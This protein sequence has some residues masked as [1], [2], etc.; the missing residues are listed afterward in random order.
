MKILIV[1]SATSRNF[2]LQIHQAFI[3][4][5]VESIKVIDKSIQFDYF[6]IK[7]KGLSGYLKAL[8][9]LRN[10]KKYDLIHAHGGLPA[11]LSVL[12]F[13][14]PVIS[15]FHGS[16]I[17]S[18]KTKLI[19]AFASLLSRKSIYV[20]QQLKEKALYK[21]NSVVI[22]CGVNLELFQPLKMEACR[23]TLNL[24]EKKKYILFS[25]SFS[26]PVKNFPLLEA[27]LKLWV[28]APPEVIELKGIGRELVPLYMNAVDVCVLTSFS[29]GSPQFI[30]EALACNR[31]VIAT[32]VGDIKELI[33]N[34]HNCRITNFTPDDLSNSIVQL[35]N[36]NISNGR[37]NMKSY[38]LGFIAAKVLKVYNRK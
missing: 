31:P 10:S 34:S 26:N 18:R 13:R 19:S 25:S 12:L 35:I 5:Q 16:D 30:K 29:E 17:N 21:R 23:R 9:E 4:E 38:E 36:E 22:P 33:G 15:T 1:C 28:G 14:E 7:Q 8:L 6:F 27:A 3:Y 11:F 2:N 32:P 24:D 20:S 37:E